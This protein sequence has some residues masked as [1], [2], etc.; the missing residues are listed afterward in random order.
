MQSKKTSFNLVESS[1]E[2]QILLPPHSTVSISETSRCSVL[3]NQHILTQSFYSSVSTRHSQIIEYKEVLKPETLIRRQVT[4]YDCL[5]SL[6][7]IG[8]DK[9]GEI[10]SS[11]ENILRH[12]TDDTSGCHQEN[13]VLYWTEE[14][15]QGRKP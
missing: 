6:L 11:E 15:S 8:V 2:W 5:P 3:K 4:R 13:I 1:L 10:V 12:W 14:T 9:S 7:G